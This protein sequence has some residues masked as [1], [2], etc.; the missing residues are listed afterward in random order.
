MQTRLE[1]RRVCLQP[2]T[3]TSS[4]MILAPALAEKGGETKT[5][6][7]ALGTTMKLTWTIS[8]R[9]VLLLDLRLALAA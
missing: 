2:L 1:S 7:V 6:A 8:R 9:W 3:S 4:R 5:Q